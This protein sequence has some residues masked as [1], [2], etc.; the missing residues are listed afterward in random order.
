[1]RPRLPGRRRRGRHLCPRRRRCGCGHGRRHV[2]LFRRLRSGHGSRGRRASGSWRR[3]RLGGPGMTRR[4]K[5]QRVDVPVRLGR[6][7]NAEMDVRLRDLGVGARGDGAN[8]LAFGDRRAHRNG[9][10]AELQERDRVTVFGAD[11][12]CPPGAGHR[13]GKGD[14]AG[15]G[16]THVAADRGTDVDSPV[17][18][19]AVR[20]VAGREPTQNRAV[21]RP[22]PRGGVRRQGEGQHA[23]QGEK[24][25]PTSVARS[26][27]HD[28]NVAGWSAVVKPGYS[29][30]R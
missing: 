25:G 28:G 21:D 27:N 18:A 1:M 8:H 10:R 4:Q 9:D 3:S 15:G 14:H 20:I 26:A 24:H 17:L 29:E 30:P 5:R 11:R 12:D 23:G 7:P 19:P 16:R 2:D 13:P 6:Q 22:A